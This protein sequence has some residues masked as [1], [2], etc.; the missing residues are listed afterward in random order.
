MH[1]CICSM[2]ICICN[3]YI[4]VI[5][6]ESSGTGLVSASSGGHNQT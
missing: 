1:I 6:K 2:H 3:V 4:Y 5:E